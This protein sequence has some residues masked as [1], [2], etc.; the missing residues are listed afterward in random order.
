MKQPGVTL[1]IL[2]FNEREA[3]EQIW[4]TLPLSLFA[5]VYVIDGGS[6]DGTQEFFKQKKVRV[7]QQKKK[8]EGQQCAKDSHMPSNKKSF[9]SQAMGTKI[10]ACSL[11]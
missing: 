4:N 11:K 8:D 5:E 6:T 1:C 3:L 2:A 10:R 9:F 7:I